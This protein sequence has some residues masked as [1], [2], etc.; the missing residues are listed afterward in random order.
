MCQIVSLSL[1]HGGL[2]IPALRDVA[3]KLRLSKRFKL[4]QSANEECRSLW[5]MS[6]DANVNLDSKI[7]DSDTKISA[8]ASLTS[9]HHKRNFEHVNSLQIQGKLIS[10]INAEFNKTEINQWTSNF[11]K[12]AALI[13]KFERKA[14]QQQLPTAANLQRWGKT[15]DPNCL[16]CQA[17]Q[18]NKHVLSKCGSLFALGRFKTRHNS[19]LAILIG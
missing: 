13:F 5:V 15:S 19:I 9:A 6:S 11:E 14:L 10:A 7:I 2:N 18:T 12:L 8:V 3:E 17:K 1:S 16:L 4:H